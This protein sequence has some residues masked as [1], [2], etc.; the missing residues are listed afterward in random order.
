MRFN[1]MRRPA[2]AAVGGVLVLL[3]SACAHEQTQPAQV[4]TTTPSASASVADPVVELLDFAH[5]LGQATPQQRADAV[6]AARDAVREHPDAHSHAKLAIAYGAPSQ[7]R[8]TPDEAARY[9]RLAARTEDA[10][11]SPAARQYLRQYAQ[12]CELMTSK[13]VRAERENVAAPA[14]PP[15]SAAEHEHP[16]N[17]R[18]LEIA[19]L[20]SELADAHR[21]LR[22]LANIENRLGDGPQ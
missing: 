21:K 3:I 14:D 15:V 8:Y 17:A 1:G 5:R 10:N 22:E 18:D 4:Q 2:T 16:A 20:Q 11:W 13:N 7:R 19:R 9:A 12:L 6:V